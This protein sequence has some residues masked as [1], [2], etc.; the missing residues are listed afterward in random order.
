MN[1]LENIKIENFRGFDQLEVNGLSKVNIFVGKNGCGKTSILEAVML[2]LGM[3][4]PLIPNYIN[5]NNRGVLFSSP[6]ENLKYLFYQLNYLN[7]PHIQGRLRNGLEHYLEIEPAFRQTNVV[8][9]GMIT[10][11][12][13]NK[14]ARL[15]SNFTFKL[16]GGK[17]ESHTN[18]AVYKEDG[19]FT[20]DIQSDQGEVEKFQG[21]FIPSFSLNLAA[22]RYSEVLK[23]GQESLVLNALKKFNPDVQD[24]KF[25]KDGI[26]FRLTGIDELL[27]SS[28]LG[29]GMRRFLSI[30]TGIASLEGEVSYI[31][32]DEIENGLH[33]AAD[34]ILWRSILSLLD[35]FNV[36]LFITTHNLE[37]LSA[38]K[39]VLEEEKYA[40]QRDICKVF[41]IANTIKKGFQAYRYSFEGLQEVIDQNIEF[42]E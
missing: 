2:L 15:N 24:I 4:N 11:G 32:I 21:V 22:D 28:M 31:M 42:R 35:T 37:V 33:Y 8:D 14:I 5:I 20:L 18:A 36:Q 13:Y 40:G 10:T 3:S 27:H 16:Q 41:T 23:K 7:K 17:K 29:D 1:Y 25:L 26:Y 12:V 9:G 38:L 19:S 6:E 34:R 39:S 30:I